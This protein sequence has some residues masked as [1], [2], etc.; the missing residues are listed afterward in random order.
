MGVRQ[1]NGQAM[2]A[3][4]MSESASVLFFLD[5]GGGE[6]TAIRL[7]AE[8]ARRLN[9]GLHAVFLETQPFALAPGSGG[10]EIV[11]SY[12]A[13][14]A[15]RAARK[16]ARQLGVPL[17][18]EVI[19][20]DRRF[21]TKA[22]V[23][24]AVVSDLVVV[25][26]GVLKE[27][28]GDW[29][30]DLFAQIPLLAGRPTLFIPKRHRGEAF[31]RCPLVA[32][33]ESRESS[34]AV[35][36]AMPFLESARDVMVLGVETGTGEHETR[37][38]GEPRLAAYLSHHGIRVQ[39]CKS[40]VSGADAGETIAQR[41]AELDTDLL[42]MGAHGHGRLGRVVLGPATRYLLDNMPVPV[43]MSH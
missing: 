7:A 28:A 16:A 2:S 42:V 41:A 5:G 22:I 9:A 39:L 43:L 13:R 33:N 14:K 12:H 1:T 21:I 15:E 26:W 4:E 35:N 31:G 11:E 24:R 25:D 34:R 17:D 8:A 37:P 19:A 36:D 10:K 3:V 29:A 23:D 20:G 38:G 40:Y 27:S 32:W 30:V 6:A 18:W